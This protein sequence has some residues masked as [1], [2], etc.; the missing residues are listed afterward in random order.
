MQP[1]KR[2]THK[3]AHSILK[4]KIVSFPW[5]KSTANAK[6]AY[7]CFPSIVQWFVR[8]A[9][10]SISYFVFFFFSLNPL[11]K[12]FGLPST[13][14]FFLWWL[15]GVYNQPIVSSFSVNLRIYSVVHLYRGLLAGLP[16]IVFTFA[17]F[18]LACIH[19]R[20]QTH[21]LTPRCP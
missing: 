17:D 5:S 19:I 9:Y 15:F 4:T 20:S 21:D 8:I 2:H 10:K 13:Q 7:T 16:S 1:N 18:C 14:I 12:L 3:N 6:L 11:P